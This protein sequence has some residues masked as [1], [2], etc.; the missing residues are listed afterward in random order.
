M[1]DNTTEIQPTET[2]KST[3]KTV[4]DWNAAPAEAKTEIYYRTGAG[5]IASLKDLQS[6]LNPEPAPPADENIA[7]R[8]YVDGTFCKFSKLP[9][10]PGFF[11]ILLN[12][13]PEGSPDAHRHVAT[14]KHQG[15]ANIICDGIN[16]LMTYQVQAQKLRD[17]QAK[18]PL[19][20]SVVVEEAKS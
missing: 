19:I 8:P 14:T 11:G 1:S 20:S 10:N 16:L 13:A 7:F 17:E 3:F 12:T 18:A 2:P 4:E 15:V 5:K 6:E 9:D